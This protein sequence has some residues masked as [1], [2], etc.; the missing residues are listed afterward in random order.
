MRAAVAVTGA[1]AALSAAGCGHTRQ[2][3]PAAAARFIES[4]GYRAPSVPALPR[5]M[6]VLGHMDL[7]FDTRYGQPVAYLHKGDLYV[8]V[9]RGD[10]HTPQVPKALWRR[11][12][13]TILIGWPSGPYGR[14]QF[15]RLVVAL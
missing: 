13:R 1:V 9:A 3:D 10:N 7:Q 11:F 14:A 12:G 5:G 6:T 2:V 15:E 8:M 4:Q